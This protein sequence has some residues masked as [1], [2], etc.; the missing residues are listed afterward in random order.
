MPAPEP[1]YR[2]Y[3]DEH[4]GRLGEE[5]FAGALPEARARLAAI[6]GEDIPERC[7]QAW[8]HACCALADHVGSAGGAHK[9]IASEHVG[10]TTV[11]YTD[12]AALEDDLR[13]IGPWLAGT[14]LL[15]AGLCRMGCRA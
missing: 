4:R 11:T 7:G 13:T 1:T 3:R 5:A 6:T 8:L 10:D 2:F 14:G 9:G 15:Y 12:Q